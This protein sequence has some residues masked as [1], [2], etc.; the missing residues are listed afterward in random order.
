MVPNEVVKTQGRGHSSPTETDFNRSK[1]KVGRWAPTRKKKVIVN[2]NKVTAT[3]KLLPKSEKKKKG[4][5]AWET[6]AKRAWRTKW[7]RETRCKHSR[8]TGLRKRAKRAGI[9]G[10]KNGMN[11]TA[12]GHRRGLERHLS[13]TGFGRKG[14]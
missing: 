5:R 10:G 12:A 9:L 3:K 4:G 13:C 8:V 6:P 2:L 11:K 7:A 1:Q 14:T